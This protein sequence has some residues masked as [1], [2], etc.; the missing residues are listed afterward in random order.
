MS[1]AVTRNRLINVTKL[2]RT[3]FYS[4]RRRSGVLTAIAAGTATLGHVY[5]LRNSGTLE[6]HVCRMRLAWLSTV[7]PSA[8]Q[9]VGFEAL[10][11]TAHT[12]AY[13]G[14]TGAAAGNPVSRAE[15]AAV[16]LY[17]ALTTTLVDRIA[18]TD[19]LTAGTQ[20]IGELLG[21]VHSHA[22]AAAA[23]VKQT[24]FEKEWITPDRHPLFIIGA[25]E[26]LVVRNLVLM[27]NSLA[28]ILEVELDGFLKDTG[29]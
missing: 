27:A 28:G 6:Y 12:V 8:A 9:R 15:G 10:K 5:A 2:Q 11:L 13:S 3:P 14:G 21:S 20:T 17:P 16:A 18:G 22:L 24:Q 1:A 7:D 23:T 26:G 4:V 19:A 29:V 25:S